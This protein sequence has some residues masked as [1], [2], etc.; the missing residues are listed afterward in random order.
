MR[1]NNHQN[2]DYKYVNKN[3]N[4]VDRSDSRCLRNRL[5][6]SGWA[7]RFSTSRFGVHRGEN[8]TE[9]CSGGFLLGDPFG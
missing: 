7:V 1:R 2:E 3:R 5:I 4:L 9:S 8:H 6:L